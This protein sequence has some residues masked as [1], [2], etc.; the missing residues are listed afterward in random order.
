MVPSCITNDQRKW[1]VSRP[2]REDQNR[3][4]FDALEQ[5]GLT[6]FKQV[7]EYVKDSGQNAALV[8]VLEHEG[9]SSL[10]R[11]IFEFVM[12]VNQYTMFTDVRYDTIR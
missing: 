10:L 9:G 8:W 6:S 2:T 1:I 4:F 12:S 3:A 5:Q 11:I 7:V